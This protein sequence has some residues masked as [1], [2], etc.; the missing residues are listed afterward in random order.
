LALEAVRRQNENRRLTTGMQI[1]SKRRSMA[2]D[3]NPNRQTI[4]SDLYLY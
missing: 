3:W 1:M 2:I 4:S